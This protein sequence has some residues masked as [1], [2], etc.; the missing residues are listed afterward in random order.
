M[1]RSKYIGLLLPFFFFSYLSQAQ[2]SSVKPDRACIGCKTGEPDPSAALDVVSDDRGILIPRLDSVQVVNDPA[3]GLLIFDESKSSFQYYNGTTWVEF[4]GDAE[5]LALGINNI[6]DGQKA[7]A[8]G[9]DN[10]TNVV[11]S[12]ATVGVNNLNTG[13][14]KSNAFGVNNTVNANGGN[15]FGFEN[16][17]LSIEGTAFGYSNT[18]DGLFYSVAFGHTN[19]VSTLGGGVAVGYGNDVM[20][21]NDG[22]AFGCLNLAGGS[23]NAIGERNISSGFRSN[24]MGVENEATQGYSS[25]FGNLNVASSDTSSAVGYSNRAEAGASNAF[26]ANNEVTGANSNAFGYQNDVTGS[27]SSAFG[28]FNQAMSFESTAFGYNNEA[29]EESST[30]IGYFNEA[31]GFFSTAIGGSNYAFGS[32]SSAFGNGNDAFGN[33][34]SAFGFSSR[35][36]GDRSSAFG[37]N[38]RSDVY[39]MTAI[40]I[41]NETPIGSETAWISTDPVFAIGNGEDVFTRSTALTILKNGKTGIGTTTPDVQLDVAG[42]GQFSKNGTLSAPQLTLNQE[43]GDFARMRFTNNNS[44]TGGN[45]DFFAIQANVKPFSSGDGRF[46]ISYQDDATIS[47]ILT[48]QVEGTNKEVGIN[49]NTPDFMLDVNGS[50][51]KPGGGDWS[52]A[53]DRRLKKDVEK[54]EDGL[55]QILKIRPVWYRYNGLY[56]M[57]TK[58]K[59]VGIIAQEMQKVAPYTITPYLATD[60]KTGNQKEFLSYNGTAVT[61]MLVNAIQEQQEMIEAKDDL[62]ESLQKQNQ[63]LEARLARLESIILDQSNTQNNT[64][65]T[66]S[67]A[68]LEQNNPNPFKGKTS[69]QYFIPKDTN[70]A[71]LRITDANGRVLKEIPIAAMGEG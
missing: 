31:E 11:F 10:E 25:A 38:A 21:G 53:S 62:V 41:Y 39:G 35:A 69:I 12:G 7:I 32:S 28:H 13:D 50:A 43:A 48:L 70:N 24:A 19:N 64:T 61:Y 60:E 8:L 55:E 65:S 3:L 26:G 68:K 34:S 51:G 15:A 18:A 4:G 46:Y 66:L 36:Y 14:D 29:I 54:F 1:R 22:N 57:P 47:N 17:V 49:D 16:T 59:Y 67:S 63:A 44:F 56:G 5:T 30:A 42:D 9:V 37:F 6:T 40:G 27:F 2:V 45:D 20:G 23:G 58:E 33:R 71:T 52:N